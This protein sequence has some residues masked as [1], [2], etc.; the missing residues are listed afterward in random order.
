MYRSSA[1]GEAVARAGDCGDA[2]SNTG[3]RRTHDEDERIALLIGCIGFMTGI[4]VGDL[5]ERGN[6]PAPGER[7]L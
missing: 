1:V 3:R 7:R 5:V 4:D 6:G 2:V